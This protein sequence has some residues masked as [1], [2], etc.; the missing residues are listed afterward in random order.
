MGCLIQMRRRFLIAF[1]VLL[2][3]VSAAPAL[4]AVRGEPNLSV[5]VADDALTPG[6]ETTVTFD[7]TNRGHLNYTR[8][9][10]LDAKVLTARGVTVSVTG[11]DGPLDVRTDTLA[12]GSIRDGSV[13]S[14]PID[15]FV[16]EDV[17][18]GEYTVELTIE[19]DYITQYI[20]S[21]GIVQERS[22]EFT[23][24]KT[25]TVEPEPRFEITDVRANASVGDSGAVTFNVTNTGEEPVRN[26]RLTLTSENPSV[27]F[28]GAAT[29]REQI[30]QIAPGE[31]RTVTV[32]ADVAEGAERRNYSLSARLDYDDVDGAPARSEELTF[33][34][35]P[36]PAQEFS[37]TNVE[38]TLR[39]GEDGTVRGTFHN[40]G[41][42]TARNVVLR[43]QTDNPNVNVQE[44]EV[45]LGDVA[46]G[47]RV[48]FAF[49]AD[50]SSSATAG[51]RQF[52]LRATYRN[53]DGDKRRSDPIDAMVSV[54]QE[55]EEFAVN[56][57]DVTFQQGASGTLAVQITNNLE[58]PVS[59][60]EAKLFTDAPLSSSD[61][62][63]FVT[64]LG[65]GESTTIVFGL[66]I[67]EGAIPKTYPA[68]VDF[69][70]E[71][72]AGETRISDTYSVPVQV[73]PM[74]SNG[75]PLPLLGG[76]GVVVLLVAGGL[77]YW[78]R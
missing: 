21:E 4:A 41:G 44:P 9:P 23:V 19:Y 68:Q 77:L 67:G 24:S 12:L 13:E 52:T 47:E 16:G 70:Y 28:A 22:E 2:L 57:V 38:S 40:T 34:F 5:T 29:V 42:S 43:L 61:D 31:T 54:G 30:G 35:V 55:R 65:A 37:V 11:A 71:T 33:G 39:V 58:E 10:S 17:E 36:G 1:G 18:P 64:I 20:P 14:A 73:E 76:V 8:N 32:E 75:L 3:L 63:A 51:D 60:I 27:T 66:G 62:E 45:A 50:V 69:R 7:I 26:A 74:E 46:P 25:L 78:R 72:A 59:N 6:A 15:V 56:G 48:K 53:G 49:D